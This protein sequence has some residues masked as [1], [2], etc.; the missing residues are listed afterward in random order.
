MSEKGK[1][2]NPW[3]VKT[4]QDVPQS[5]NLSLTGICQGRDFNFDPLKAVKGPSGTPISIQ[6]KKLDQQTS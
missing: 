4:A 1:D 5:K 3:V 6:P 2:K